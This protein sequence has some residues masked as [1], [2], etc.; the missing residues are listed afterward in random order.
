MPTFLH[1]FYCNVTESPFTQQQIKSTDS[2]QL[3]VF[4]FYA[5]CM[6]FCLW[7]T[8]FIIVRRSYYS[9]FFLL[10]QYLLGMATCAA[11]MFSTY[12]LYYASKEIR[13][14]DYCS[15]DD[16]KLKEA[17]PDVQ[18]QL[19]TLSQSSYAV[20]Y[21]TTFKLVLSAIQIC[22]FLELYFKIDI[23]SKAGLGLAGQGAEDR[24]NPIRRVLYAV[25][26]CFAGTSLY[27]T[28]MSVKAGQEYYNATKWDLLLDQKY[29]DE[30][31]RELRQMARTYGLQSGSLYIVLA[32]LM[33]LTA[34]LMFVQF[35]KADLFGG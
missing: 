4:V 28:I 27:F 33:A 2:A 23:L 1:P 31:D 26:C 15:M 14:T 30:E 21:S 32:V 5:V 8:A 7:N 20:C 17:T 18:R 9:S 22:Y 16:K 25:V 6:L 3:I 24:I 19:M 10:L 35:A 34:V 13:M 29:I 12:T 11:K